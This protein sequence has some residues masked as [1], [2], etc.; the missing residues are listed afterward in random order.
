MVSYR[1]SKKAVES[2]KPQTA[3]AMIPKTTVDRLQR[4]ALQ[5]FL[6]QP[7]S[8]RG[9]YLVGQFEF[10]ARREILNVVV[11]I[12]RGWQCLA[13]DRRLA[14]GQERAGCHYS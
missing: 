9:F 12:C 14:T 2:G 7:V 10:G 5:L 4:I 3:F 13:A 1:R 11:Q 8:A 6:F